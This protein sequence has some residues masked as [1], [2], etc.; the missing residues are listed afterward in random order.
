MKDDPGSAFSYG[1]IDGIVNARS[2]AIVGAS[3]NLLTAWARAM[4]ELRVRTPVYP[5]ILQCSQQIELVRG[6]VYL[7]T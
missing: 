3:D 2:P 6:W 7:A 1:Q 4:W 5:I